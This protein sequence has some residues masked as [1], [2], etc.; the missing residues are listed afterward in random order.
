VKNG[1]RG[2]DAAGPLDAV[3]FD[4]DGVLIDSGAH[5]RAAWR[6]MLEEVGIVPDDDF[7]RLTI[8]RPAEEAVPLVLGLDVSPDDAWRLASRKRDH[9]VRLARRGVPAVPGVS[10]F[11]ERLAAAGVPCAVATSA[12]SHDVHRLLYG[13]GVAQHFRAVITSEDVRFGKPDPEVYLRAARALRTLPARCLAFED[14]IVGVHAA[15][16]AGMKVVGVT[17]SY[18]GDELVDAGAVRTIPSFEGIDW[19]L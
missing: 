13:I 3:V 19:P 11:V 4:M 2:A 16:D 10:A 15:R 6:A 9:Y 14:S 18:G 17:T 5:H 1:A 8:G 12:S 7:W